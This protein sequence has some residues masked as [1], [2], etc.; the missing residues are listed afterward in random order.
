MGAKDA[1]SL[2]RLIA[3]ARERRLVDSIEKRGRNVVFSAGGERFTLS[4]RWACEFLDALL[5]ISSI[6]PTL[7]RLDHNDGGGT[8]ETSSA[9]PSP[10]ILEKSA[11][12]TVSAEAS[13]PRSA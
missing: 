10:P 1:Y 11:P 7:N 8:H 5:R 2:N 6:Y 13:S 9:R 12:P 4:Q 3:A